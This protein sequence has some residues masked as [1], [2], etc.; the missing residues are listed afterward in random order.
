PVTFSR[1]PVSRNSASLPLA[2]QFRSSPKFF[3]RFCPVALPL[4]GFSQLP[5]RRS[6]S[7]RQ[8]DRSAKLGY[9]AIKIAGFEQ[10]SPR[11]GIERSRL[12]TV[13]VPEQLLRA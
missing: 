13:R 3:F 11:I 1:G 4:Q 2:A 8:I 12:Q 7:G 9:R 5:M 10:L 6:I